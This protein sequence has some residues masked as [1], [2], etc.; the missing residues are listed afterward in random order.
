MAATFESFRHRWHFGPPPAAHTWLLRLLCCAALG[1]TGYLA[2]TALSAGDVAGC[3]GGAVWDC[4]LALHSRWAKVL[5]VPVS[6][7]AFALYGVILAS[8]AFC[9]PTAP[10]SRLRVA[11]S[12]A[13]IGAFAAGLAAVWFIGL[14][15]FAVGHLCVYCIA[16]HLCGLALCAAI[17]W[18]R[19]AGSQST[20]VLAGVSALGVGLLIAA[21]ALSAPP[22]TFKVEQYP[23]DGGGQTTSATTVAPAA[24][25]ANV[26]PQEKPAQHVFEAPDAPDDPAEK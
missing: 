13:T 7:P 17:L 3:S 16:A 26:K 20:A 12:I 18:K 8:L 2:V 23:A 1:I 22:P 9:R 25:S 11:W 15:V 14:Q 5:G 6:V 19:P 10:R 24:P 21:Q 4:G